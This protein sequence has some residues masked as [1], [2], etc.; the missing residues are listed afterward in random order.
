VYT[1]FKN[2]AAAG[3]IKSGWLRVRDPGFTISH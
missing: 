3:I 1:L 2:M